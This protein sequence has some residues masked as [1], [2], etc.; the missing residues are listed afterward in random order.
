MRRHGLWLNHVEFYPD[1]HGGTLRWHIG[2]H[3]DRSDEALRFLATEREIGLDQ[4]DYY[5]AFAERVARVRHDLRDLLTKLRADGST[6]AGYGA[7]AKGTTLLNYTGIG[8]D[9]VDYV[10]D[11]N[12]HKQ[13]TYMPGTNQHVLAPEALLDRRPDYVLLLAWN[14]ADEIIAQQHDYLAAGGRF[15]VPVPTPEVI[16]G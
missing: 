10:V 16:G 12:V 3:E 13:G 15:I 14:F 6:I 9:L 7:A 8:T 5:A 4:I 1:L 11:R 2:H